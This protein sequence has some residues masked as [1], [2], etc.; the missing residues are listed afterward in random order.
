MLQTW[1]TARLSIVLVL[2]GLISNGCASSSQNNSRMGPSPERTPA[3]NSPYST[4]DGSITV[5]RIE[6]ICELTGEYDRA[7]GRQ[8]FNATETRF[9]LRGTDLGASFRHRGELIFLFGDSFASPGVPMPADL[10][11]A[12]SSRDLQ[13]DDCLRLEIPTDR[14]GVYIPIDVKSPESDQSIPTGPFEVPTGGFSAGGQMYIF[15]TVNAPERKQIMA[16]S[17]LAKSKNLKSRWQ[18][19]YTFST[20]RF[21][22]VAPLVHGKTVY[23]WGSGAYRASDAYLASSPIDQVEK[24]G[25]LRYFKGLDPNHSPLWSENESDAVPLFQQPCLGELSVGWNE[26]LKKWMMLY[27]CGVPPTI[28]MRFADQ[29]WG[30]WSDELTLFDGHRDG[31]YCSFMYHA[32]SDPSALRADCLTARDP[33]NPKLGESYGPYLIHA[34]TKA[35]ENGRSTIYFV[36]STWNP[37]NTV[38]M[39]ATLQ[40][41]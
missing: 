29:P 13:P 19:L 18:G 26:F 34:L 21:I 2:A 15:K 12:A 37:Y 39:R 20:D 8:A 23:Y 38:L 5:S 10:D 41:R 27:S 16:R 3:S 25:S 4:P 35:G 14:N 17:I 32:A 28:R 31:G 40:G 1:K 11:V 7:T 6:K 9:K 30:P 33:E 22:N 36:L 24:K